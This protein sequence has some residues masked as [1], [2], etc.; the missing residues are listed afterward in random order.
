MRFWMILSVL[1]L[2]S[3]AVVGA[4]SSDG[5]DDDGG[6]ADGSNAPSEV[7][8]E[9]IP[10]G[11]GRLYGLAMIVPGESYDGD[12]IFCVGCNL[13]IDAREDYENY[14]ETIVDE[15]GWY[16]VDL[17]PDDYFFSLFNTRHALLDSLADKLDEDVCTL[18]EVSDW[19]I[20]DDV[21]ASDIPM[22]AG[23]LRRYDLRMYVSCASGCKSGKCR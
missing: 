19:E 23:D 16:V 7:F 21:T 5:D 15:N 1:F 9:A 3:M 20:G 14:A 6:A 10:E 12:S 2:S 13:G 18:Y 4:C 22:R 11:K 17:A 8:D